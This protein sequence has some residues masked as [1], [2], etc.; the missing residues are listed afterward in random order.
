MATPEEL[1]ALKRIGEVES[2]LTELAKSEYSSTEDSF[3]AAEISTQVAGPGLESALVVS[4]NVE[5]AAV[6]NP[7]SKVEL[8]PAELAEVATEPQPASP[9]T[10]I[11]EGFQPL[12]AGNPEGTPGSDSRQFA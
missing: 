6:N 12:A 2:A 11:P 10:E 4:G 3:I 7:A 5:I 8:P 1:D 9:P